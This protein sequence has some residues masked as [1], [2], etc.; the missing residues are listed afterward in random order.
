VFDED[1]M[2][3]VK[4]WAKDHGYVFY[5]C[6]DEARE[7]LLKGDDGDKLVFDNAT[8]AA[9][10]VFDNEDEVAVQGPSLASLAHQAGHKLFVDGEGIPEYV[11]G[12]MGKGVFDD[13]Q[14][15][16]SYVTHVMGWHAFASAPEAANWVYEHHLQELI[17]VARG[18]GHLLFKDK[19]EAV[20]YVSDTLGKVV[21]SRPFLQKV[22]D[23]VKSLLDST[24]G[25]ALE[26]PNT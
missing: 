14:A 24:L 9:Q 4:R 25:V 19:W 11:R 7:K 21:V 17:S 1:D 8:E 13:D 16:L 15:I 6:K 5:L 26:D 12:A 10:W 18:Q 22:R 20:D 3:E 2:D 23:D